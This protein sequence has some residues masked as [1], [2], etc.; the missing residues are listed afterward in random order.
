[1]LQPSN[2][3]LEAEAIS[4]AQRDRSG[5]FPVTPPTKGALVRPG[6]AMSFTRFVLSANRA[7]SRRLYSA[8][9]VS[10]TQHDV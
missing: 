5:P 2:L 4:S 1:M 9:L 6:A 7:V 8:A 3:Q 10:F